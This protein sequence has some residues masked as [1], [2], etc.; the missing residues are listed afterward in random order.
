[1]GDARKTITKL[2]DKEFDIIFLDPFSPKKCPELWTEEFLKNIYQKTAQ[3]GILT[4]YSC[5]KEVRE[6]LTKAGFNVTNGPT[7]GRRGPATI[8]TKTLIN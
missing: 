7:I 2:P 5:A 1:M 3:G 6:N 4:T 8:A